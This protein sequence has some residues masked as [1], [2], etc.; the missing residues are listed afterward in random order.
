MQR[1]QGLRITTLCLVACLL[2]A[3][4]LFGADPAVVGFNFLK[5]SWGARSAAMGDVGVA[6]GEGLWGLYF[7]PATTADSG[8]G[9]VGFMHHEYIFETRREFIG[10]WLPA[11]GG[12][13]T[14]GL[15][16]FSVT[17]LEARQY[18]TEEPAGLFD[19]HEVLWFIGYAHS[20]RDN[21]SVGVTAKYAYEKIE[22]V[23]AEALAFDFGALWQATPQIKIGAALR[24]LGDKPQFRS[25]AVELPLTFAFGSAAYIAGTLVS[26]DIS[27]PKEADTR[28]N[29][30]AERWLT[31]YLALRGG[32][33]VGY[34]AE[35]FALGIGFRHDIWSVDY[36]FVPHSSGLGPGHRFALTVSWR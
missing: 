6:A 20:L 3:V 30:G 1:R 17:D 27:F 11:Y 29:L 26:G 7:N 9:S 2:W 5:V 34:D 22:T 21:L 35:D 15:D 36:A 23:S 4:Q 12:G 14:A 28:I 24:H 32:Y 31:E 33:K 19:A 16:F 10:G 13:V 18:P 25:E 8:R